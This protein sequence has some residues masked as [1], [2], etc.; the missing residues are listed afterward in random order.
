MDLEE[1]WEEEEEEGVQSPRS[2]SPKV[3]IRR[4]LPKMRL[5]LVFLLGFLFGA[6]KGNN[7]MRDGHKINTIVLI[8]VLFARINVG[9]PSF[10]FSIPFSNP[11][12]SS[13][14]GSISEVIIWS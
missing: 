13:T 4:V 3:S 14:R 9:K 8:T 2:S 1:D 11:R 12:S 10:S 6:P 5:A 7:G